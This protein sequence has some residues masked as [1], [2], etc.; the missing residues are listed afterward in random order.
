MTEASFTIRPVTSESELRAARAIIAEYVASISSFACASFA[1]QNVEAEL[2]DL[3]GEYVA[4][5]GGLWLAWMSSQ[6]EP[7]GCIAL[8]PVKSHLPPERIRDVAEIKRMYTRPAARGMGVARRMC[9]VVMKFAREA[10]YSQVWLDSDTE[11][12]AALKLYRSL[13]FVT[14]DRYN[15]DPDAKTVYLGRAI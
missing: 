6:A 11:L 15:T 2:A 3:P 14:I 7:V 13:G 4:P 10:G 9:E 1:H 8:R 5:R 12:H